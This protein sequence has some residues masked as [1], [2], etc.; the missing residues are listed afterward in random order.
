MHYFLLYQFSR[1]TACFFNLQFI[2]SFM[3]KICWGKSSISV[4]YKGIIILKRIKL[5][6][7]LCIQTETLLTKECLK[8]KTLVYNNKATNLQIIIQAP[9][10]F[11]SDFKVHAALKR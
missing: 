9:N 1:K 8:I 4:Q 3:V 10:E 5:S 6:F 7:Q 2:T 11:P